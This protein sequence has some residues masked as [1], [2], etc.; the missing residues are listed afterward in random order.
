MNF[1]SARA[2]R[3]TPLSKAAWGLLW[4][5][6]C[7]LADAASSGTKEIADLSLEELAG[8]EVTSVSRRGEPL[9]AAPASIYVIT[10]DAIRRAGASSLPEALR[11]APNLQV[12]RIDATQYAISARGF[13]NAIGNKLLVLIDGR[14]VYAHFFSGVLWDQQDVMLD[15]VARIEVISGPGATLWGAN[16]VNGVINIITR[17]SAD[18]QGLLV[19][20]GG[21]GSERSAALRYG[22]ALGESGHL[23]VYAKTAKLNHT[24]TAAETAVRDGNERHQL[25]FRADWAAGANS[26]TVQ[27]DAYRTEA[28]HRGFFG[29][30]ELTPIAS[31]GSNLLGRWTRRLEGGSELRLQAYLD[32]SEREDALLYKPVTELA[33]VELQHGLSVGEHMLVWGGGYRRARDTIDPGV[34]FGFVPASRT[35]A[36][37]NFFVQDDIALMKGLDLTLGLKLEHNDYTGTE[38][39][40]NLRLAWQPAASQLLWAALSR[41]VR[42]PARLDRDIRLPP[43]GPPYII[44]GGPDFV[45]EGAN[46]L[47]L[48]YRAQPHVDWSYSLTAFLHDWRNLRSGQPPP[49]A[50]VQ[51][52]IDGRTWGVEGW[53]TWQALPNWRLSAGLSTLKKDLRLRADS[54]DPVG[55]ANLGDDPE[56]QGSLR[57]AF[58]PAEG[59]EFDIS[60]RRVGA[61]PQ[62][63]VPAYTA[64][65]ARY[66]WRI[67]PQVELSL[68]GQNLFRSAHPEF[69][70]SLLAPGRS[71]FGPSLALWLRCSL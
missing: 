4:M 55:P 23:R 9:S 67:T 8:I 57:S 15:D 31:A 37:T 35:L 68:V 40:P 47:E 56:Y 22:A 41:A 48:G 12:A 19:L 36:W 33:D 38:T 34:L 43:N 16:A 3:K 51:N 30:F 64:V 62:A 20:A 66:G 65:D 28:E 49:N 32:R 27:G 46:V 24:E 17:S 45:S 58:N 29:P 6:A 10:H 2:R 70:A 53:A 60:V 61:L 7:P 11:L 63:S 50:M 44:A 52:K 59:Q 69:A 25:G 13:N 18:T 21:G 26:F 71:E 1:T 54:T 5:L 39:L 42:A 14:T